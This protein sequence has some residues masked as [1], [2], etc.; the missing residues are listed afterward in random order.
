MAG[1]FAVLRVLEARRV[2][3]RWVQ[4]WESLTASEELLWC[5]E[6]GGTGLHAADLGC[7]LA[8]SQE[9]NV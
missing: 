3:F 1:S 9:S 4:A 8:R 6:E 2:G 5:E 7:K